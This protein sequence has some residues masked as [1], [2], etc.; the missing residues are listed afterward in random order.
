[1]S[2]CCRNVALQP[3]YNVQLD[4]IATPRIMFCNEIICFSWVPQPVCPRLM[5]FLLMG[6]DTFCT[7]HVV[8]SGPLYGLFDGQGQSF[9]S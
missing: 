1:M 8:A 9:E 5:P 7:R 3:K 4:N 2:S 6:Q